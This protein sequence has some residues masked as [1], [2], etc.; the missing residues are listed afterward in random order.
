[1][2]FKVISGYPGTSQIRLAMERGEVQAMS[3]TLASMYAG[4]PQFLKPGAIVPIV[5]FGTKRE[6]EWPDAPTPVEIAKTEED[7]QVFEV[8]SIAAEFGRS[9]WVGPGVPQD[10]LKVLRTAFM[11][12]LKD[13]KFLEEGK[14]QKML[15]RFAPGEEMD[16]Y[17][18]R[19]FEVGDS[20]IDRLRSAMPK[21][22]KKKK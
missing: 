7:R 2:K 11:Q 18:K 4:A 13:E 5:Q 9:Y 22:K 15:L 3:M 17:V 20:A 19:I 8:L 16:G 1:L 12:M 21:R 6:K 14:R 10:R